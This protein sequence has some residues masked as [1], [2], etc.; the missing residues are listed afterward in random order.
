MHGQRM[1]RNYGVR[2]CI[3]AVTPSSSPQ[4]VDIT[5]G[6]VA[7][8]SPARGQPMVLSKEFFGAMAAALE[9]PEMVAGLAKRGLAPGDV[10]CLRL[11]AGYY[12]TPEF[13]NRV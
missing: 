7:A 8:V 12:P 2:L 3:R 1:T 10:F 4:N 13:R 11:T 6:A 5:G 9:H